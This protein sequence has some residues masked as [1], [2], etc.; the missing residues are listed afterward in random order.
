MNPIPDCPYCNLPLDGPTVNGLHAECEEEFH[1][2]LVEQERN[3]KY[4]G[5]LNWRDSEG[6]CGTIGKFEDIEA[7]SK[8]EAEKIVM[9]EFWDERLDAASCLPIIVFAE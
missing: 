3:M 2:V 8:V 4:T 7:P 5:V 9:A 1:E 6:Q